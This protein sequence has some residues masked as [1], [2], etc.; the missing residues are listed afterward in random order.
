MGETAPAAM[1]SEA[2]FMLAVLATPTHPTE[3]KKI[4]AQ[5]ICK[6]LS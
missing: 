2:G 4:A 1:H 6:P 3:R 5:R